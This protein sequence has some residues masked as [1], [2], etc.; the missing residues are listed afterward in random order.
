M[1]TLLY[2]FKIR[3]RF[4]GVKKFVSPHNRY[5]V[6]CLGE[7]N[8]IVGIAREHVDTLDVVSIHFKL[9]YFISAKFAL[10]DKT[11]TGHH[12]EELPLGIMPMLP[13]CDAGLGN[14]N[15][16]LP[17]IQRMNQLGEAAAVVYVH[18]YRECDFF[19]GKIAEVCTI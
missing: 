15:T 6:L 5:K 13:L 11:M 9:N 2:R 17:C 4:I 10:L 19:L 3:I 12:N 7:V 1:T 16:H 8:D 14:V 18:L